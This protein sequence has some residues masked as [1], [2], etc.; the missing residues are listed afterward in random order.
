VTWIVRLG[1]CRPPVAVRRER[2][3][4]LRCR[5][6]LV[7]S[8]NEAILRLTDGNSESELERHAIQLRTLGLT[9]PG[10]GVDWQLHDLFLSSADADRMSVEGS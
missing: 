4:S 3:W 5:C 10:M 8:S 7:E 1:S 9:R 2:D 6:A